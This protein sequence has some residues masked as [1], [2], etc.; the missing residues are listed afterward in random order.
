MLGF[1]AQPA[2]MLIVCFSILIGAVDMLLPDDAAARDWFFSAEPCALPC[3][4]GIDPG[5]TRLREMMRLLDE[6]N[7]ARTFEFNYSIDPETGILMWQW[8]D[9]ATPLIDQRRQGTAWAQHNLIRWIDLPMRLSYGEV[10][11]ALRAPD[12]GANVA[13]PPMGVIDHYLLYEQI[14]VQIR[15]RLDCPVTPE[16]LWKSPVSLLIGGEWAVPYGPYRTPLR[17]GCR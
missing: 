15:I 8:D 4:G 7:W 17:V 13:I 16:R 9:S 3:W 14:G 12:E 2:L 1:I 5:V 6:H 10:W 11:L